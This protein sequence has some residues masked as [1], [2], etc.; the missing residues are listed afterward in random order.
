[1]SAVVSAVLLDP[2][3]HAVMTAMAALESAAVATRP[4]RRRRSGV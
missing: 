3:P 4:G 2:P 1:V